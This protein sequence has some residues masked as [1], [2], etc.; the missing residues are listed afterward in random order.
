[1]LPSPVT[2]LRDPRFEK[3]GIQ[4]SLKRDDLIGGPAQGNKFR[5]MKHH[6]LQAQAE[7]K[8]KLLT[9]GGAFS[10]HLYATAYLAA[11]HNLASIGFVRGEI[12]DANPTVIAC[13]NWGMRLVS[14]TREQFSKHRTPAHYAALQTAYPDGYLIPEGGAGSLGVLGCQALGEEL[15]KQGPRYTHWGCASATGTT[16]AGLLAARSHS[17]YSI[18]LLAFDV[19]RSSKS[20]TIQSQNHGVQKVDAHLGGFGKF[21]AELIEFIREF[22]GMHEIILDPVYTG[23]MMYSFFRLVDKGYFRPGEHIILIHTGGH[24][25]RAGFNYRFGN[26]LP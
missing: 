26:L 13:R 25:G 10:N 5:K 22:E 8:T 3:W 20:A 15:L 23:K 21:P 19:L 4:V 16:M 2:V 1:M 7:K 17:P 24:Q 9:F 11:A 12:D 18:G 14:L 6:L